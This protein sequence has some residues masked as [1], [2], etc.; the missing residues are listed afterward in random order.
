MA[1]EERKGKGEGKRN[2]DRS[3]GWRE[4]IQQGK[5]TELK[6]KEERNKR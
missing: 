4:V 5:V 6:K 1:E 3:K 2:R